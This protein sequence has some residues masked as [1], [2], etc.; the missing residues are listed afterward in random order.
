M[1]YLLCSILITNYII[2]VIIKQLKRQLRIRCVDLHL[3]HNNEVDLHVRLKTNTQAKIVALNVY[4]LR[5]YEC[6]RILI[7][8][9]GSSLLVPG[10][11]V[12]YGTQSARKKKVT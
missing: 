12:S 9:R 10:K 5:V 3:Y 7:F 6:G 4:V 1:I 2:N 8:H 11:G